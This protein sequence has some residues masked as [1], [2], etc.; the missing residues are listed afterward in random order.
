MLVKL[1]QDVSA[2][3]SDIENRRE[4]F[5]VQKVT[6]LIIKRGMFLR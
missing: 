6:L 2:S 1:G 5:E 4:Q 3:G